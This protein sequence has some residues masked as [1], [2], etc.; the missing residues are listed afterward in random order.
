MNRTNLNPFPKYAAKPSLLQWSWSR[1]SAIRPSTCAVDDFIL[2][3]NLIINELLVE[4]DYRNDQ[5]H[6]GSY[7]SM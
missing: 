6:H 1:D 4:P 3:I 5:S 7:T 2:W